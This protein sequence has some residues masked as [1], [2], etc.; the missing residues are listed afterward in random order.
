MEYIPVIFYKQYHRSV[1]SS[2]YQNVGTVQLKVLMSEIHI[3]RL[4]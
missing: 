3:F 1:D 4:D 2:G